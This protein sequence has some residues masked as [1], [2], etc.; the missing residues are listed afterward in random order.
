MSIFNLHSWMW[1]SQNSQSRYRISWSSDQQESRNSN[2]YPSIIIIESVIVVAQPLV[3]RHKWSLEAVEDL[4][5]MGN[6]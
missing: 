1:S 6:L 2:Y 5:H 3:L 4:M